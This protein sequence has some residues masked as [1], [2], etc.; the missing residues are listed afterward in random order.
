MANRFRIEKAVDDCTFHFDLYWNES[1]RLTRVAW[2]E[3][4]IAPLLPAHEQPPYG[5]AA[6]LRDLAGFFR[7][8]APLLPLHWDLLDTTEL[9]DFSR[10]VY[11]ATLAI[12]HGETR[13]YAWVAKK[14]GSPLAA[15]AV[16]QA[17]RKNPFPI[18]IPCH[19]VVSDKTIGGFMG[20]DNPSDL[21]MRFKLWLLELE[22]SYRSPFFPFLE[23]APRL[24]AVACARA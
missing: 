24:Q 21:E 7:D 5:V 11:A 9:T 3:D 14:M 2:N 10:K 12:P 19:R 20:T 16:G 15:R 18:L 13:T 17:L 6:V 8:G 23:S 4:S 1:G 22:G